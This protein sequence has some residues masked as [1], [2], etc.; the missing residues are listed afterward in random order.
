MTPGLSVGISS[1]MVHIPDILWPSHYIA[2]LF[3]AVLPLFF[4][5]ERENTPGESRAKLE[6]VL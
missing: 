3:C 2:S 4:F 6:N 1:L 5:P